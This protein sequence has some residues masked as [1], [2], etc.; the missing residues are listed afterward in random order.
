MEFPSDM[1]KDF[2]KHLK[3]ERREMIRS[4]KTGQEESIWVTKN[5]DNHLWDCLVYQIGAALMF[6]LFDAPPAILTTAP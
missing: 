3:A 2:E 5:R 1:S 4:P 6:Q